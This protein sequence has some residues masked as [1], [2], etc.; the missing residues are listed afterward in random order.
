MTFGKLL[1]INKRHTSKLA[2]AGDSSI[3][4]PLMEHVE[5][6]VAPELRYVYIDT[7]LLSLLS[8]PTSCHRQSTLQGRSLRDYTTALLRADAD[9][10]TNPSDFMERNFYFFLP[11]QTSSLGTNLL[12]RGGLTSA[13]VLHVIEKLSE[14]PQEAWEKKRIEATMMQAV[15]SFTNI[16]SNPSL[17]DNQPIMLSEVQRLHQ[18]QLHQFLRAVIAHGRPGMGMM[19]AMTVLG[20]E[21]SLQ[22]LRHSMKES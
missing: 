17:A 13:G 19:D 7:P 21:V 16:N 15:Q 3:L 1:H 22:R 4:V 5:R 20:K 12:D 2:A 11:P 8:E 6:T 10:Y 9:N 14:V 18:S